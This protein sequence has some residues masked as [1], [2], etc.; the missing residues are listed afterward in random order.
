MSKDPNDVSG[1]VLHP[2][3]DTSVIDTVVNTDRGACY[4]IVIAA[5][6]SGDIPSQQRLLDKLAAYIGDF[7]SDKYLTRYGRPCRAYCKITVAIHSESD[8]VIFELLEKC[9]AW[10][11][12]NNISFAVKTD[13]QGSA[14]H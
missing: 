4:G 6:L 3:R 2:V 7:Y 9:R 12:D 11:E 5:P 8:A 13:I 10:V 14:A 1:A